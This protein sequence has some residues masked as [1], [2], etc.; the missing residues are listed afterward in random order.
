MCPKLG[1]WLIGRVKFSQAILL[2]RIGL[3]FMRFNEL[4]NISDILYESLFNMRRFIKIV[5]RVT[6]FWSFFEDEIYSY[7]YAHSFSFFKNLSE[8][9]S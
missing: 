9:S 1:M 4:K 3:L 8:F 5:P 6:S 2:M 7:H